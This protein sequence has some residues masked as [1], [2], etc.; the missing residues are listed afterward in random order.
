MYVKINSSKKWAQKESTV[1]KGRLQKTNA[2]MILNG[3]K[4][5][6][7]T[8]RS[9]TRQGCPLVRQGALLFNIVL[10]VLATE[11]RKEKQIK[12]IQTGKEEIKLYLQIT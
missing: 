3:E 9:E 8:L 11:I 10:D 6:A 4:L 1:N 7:F 12:G 5:K 2:N